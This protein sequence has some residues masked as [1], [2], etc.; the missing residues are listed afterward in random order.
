MIYN[1]LYFYYDTNNKYYFYCPII[2]ESF[3]QKE[4]Y[5]RNFIDK[6]KEII[7]KTNIK[8]GLDINNFKNKIIYIKLNENIIIS[9][10]EIFIETMKKQLNDKE[11][12]DKNKLILKDYFI[13]KFE[14]INKEKINAIKISI[15]PRYL[16]LNTLDIP[17]IFF[18]ILN[19]YP[20]TNN[21]MP[22]TELYQDGKETD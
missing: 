15:Y 2:F 16:I 8:Q 22:E 6:E 11:N 4:L 20:D 7:L 17:I 3:C 12:S 13:I 10:N 19:K 14:Y 21:K 9:L 1:K 5:I 18:S